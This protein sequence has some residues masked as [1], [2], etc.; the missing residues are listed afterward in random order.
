M[1]DVIHS[2]VVADRRTANAVELICA[3]R[4]AFGYGGRLPELSPGEDLLPQSVIRSLV[5]ANC[6][7]DDDHCVDSSAARGAEPGIMFRLLY[8]QFFIQT[9]DRAFCRA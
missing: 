9:P 5:S 1:R 4:K 6:N 8:H 2:D 3:G 7:G